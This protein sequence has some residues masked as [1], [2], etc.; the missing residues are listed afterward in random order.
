[1]LLEAPQAKINFLLPQLTGKAKEWD[2]VQLVVD[3][4]AFF[5]LQPIEDGFRLVH[6]AK[7]GA[8]KVLVDATR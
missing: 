2:L 8:L 4:H 1:M 5:N 7:I 6:E 3:E